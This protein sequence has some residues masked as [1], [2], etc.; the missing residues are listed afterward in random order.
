MDH[1]SSPELLQSVRAQATLRLKFGLLVQVLMLAAV[2]WWGA[3]RP[4]NQLWEVGGIVATILFD[5]L[6]AVIFYRLG[7]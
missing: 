3:S 4:E 2:G 6:A 1:L 5:G 7:L